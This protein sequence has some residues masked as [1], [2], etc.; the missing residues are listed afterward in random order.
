LF[1]PAEYESVA[2]AGQVGFDCE[3]YAASVPVAGVLDPKTKMLD[4]DGTFFYHGSQPVWRTRPGTMFRYIT[5]G[6]G[7]WGSPLERTT[8][9]VL[10][11][12]RD[13]YISIH[14]AYEQYG[15]VIVGDALT[16]PEGLIVD[17][18]RTATRRAELAAAHEKSTS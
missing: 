4:P 8:N 18:D 3:T 9:R 15:V 7:G 16:D 6:G 17:A 14:E 13:E 5:G 12:V 2:E 10:A 11:D 1:P